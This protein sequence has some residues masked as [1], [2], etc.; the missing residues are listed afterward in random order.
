MAM[1]MAMGMAM[2][3]VPTEK[4]KLLVDEKPNVGHGFV[5]DCCGLGRGIHKA[6]DIFLNNLYLQQRFVLSFTKYIH[7][8][9]SCSVSC[10]DGR[11]IRGMADER[12]QTTKALLWHGWR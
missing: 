12:R 5:D 6:C 2:V 8:C 7:S 3:D 1:E 10:F 9:I 11:H 4:R